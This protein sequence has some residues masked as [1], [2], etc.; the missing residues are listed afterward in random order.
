[1]FASSIATASPTLR[2]VIASGG[3]CAGSADVGSA[4]LR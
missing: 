3:A 1:M 4:L 2:A